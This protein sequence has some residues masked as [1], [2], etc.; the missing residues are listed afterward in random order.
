MVAVSAC[1]V[2]AKSERIFTKLH[3]CSYRF[4]VIV[5]S[6]K[7]TAFCLS[8]YLCVGVWRNCSCLHFKQT[9]LP[10]CKITINIGRLS[11]EG[12]HLRRDALKGS[13]IADKIAFRTDTP[14]RRKTKRCKSNYT[15]EKSNVQEMKRGRQEDAR[16]GRAAGS[17]G[18]QRHRMT[19][20][21]A[22]AAR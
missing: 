11:R 9:S 7:Q 5:M 19:L 13:P 10:G 3:V 12:I 18:A 2:Y 22:V 15:G 1:D 21:G 6:V 14:A 17:A 4:A 20:I 16:R 8:L